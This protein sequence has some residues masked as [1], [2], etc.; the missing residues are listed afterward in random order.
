MHPDPAS[1]WSQINHDGNIVRW[2]RHAKRKM[3][4]WRATVTTA[5]LLKRALDVGGSVGALLA[6]SPIFIITSLLIKL[7]DRGPVFSAR[8]AWEPVVDFS[9]CGSSAPWLSMRIR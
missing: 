2:G 5:H 3:K 4:I 8:S 7:E 6:F 1:Y 9:E